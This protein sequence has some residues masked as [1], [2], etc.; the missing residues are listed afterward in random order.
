MKK[1]TY[2][3]QETCQVEKY[4]C[5]GCYYNDNEADKHIPRID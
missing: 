2:K 4:G 5:E 1:C 3:E